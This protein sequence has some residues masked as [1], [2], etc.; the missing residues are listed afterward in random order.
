[1]KADSFEFFNLENRLMEAV[2]LGQTA[3]ADKLLKE[4]ILK[5]HEYSL[6]NS[7][8]DVKNLCISLNSLLRKS[9]E[10]SGVPAMYLKDTSLELISSINLIHQISEAESIIERITMEYLKLVKTTVQN[11]YS[12][13][14][15]RA[16]I[17]IDSDLRRDVSLNALAHFNNMSA[18][19]FSGLFKAETGMTLTDY[20][21]QKRIKKAKQLLKTT[22]LQIKE[23]SFECGISD[24]NYFSKLFKRY[25]GISPKEFRRSLSE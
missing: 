21:N 1:M 2:A 25:V 14:V 13:P 17:R 3:N 7:I 22:G 5:T 8:T 6:L 19:Y 4:Y 9:A 18:G 10:K 24:D 16:I 15:K 12:T 23:I 20:V 11:S